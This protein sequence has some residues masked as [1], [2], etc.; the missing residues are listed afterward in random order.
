VVPGH[1][2]VT[3]RL[4]ATNPNGVMLV[5]ILATSLAVA[6]QLKLLG[7]AQLVPCQDDPRT[8]A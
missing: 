5:T 1:V 4:E 2:D 3:L 8:I 7:V 6:S